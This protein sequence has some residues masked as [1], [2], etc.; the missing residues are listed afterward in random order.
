[1]ERTIDNSRGPGAAVAASIPSRNYTRENVRYRARSGT[2]SIKELFASKF[3]E[4][5]LDAVMVLERSRATPLRRYDQIPMVGTDLLRQAKFIGHYVAGKAVAFVGDADGMNSLLGMLGKLGAP[6]PERMLV[7]DFDE[8]VLEVARGLAE[9]YGFGDRLDLR[10][11]NAFDPVP[12]DLPSGYDWFYTNP[13]YGARNDGASARLFVARGI[14]LTGHHPG[15]GC[16]ILPYDGE[17]EWTRR[18]MLATQEFLNAAG[19]VVRE[20]VSELHRYHLDD[21]RGLAS[22]SLLVE[23]VSVQQDKSLYAGRRV[24]P[25]EIPDFYGASVPPPYPRYI[26]ADGSEDHGWDI[27]A[28]QE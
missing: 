13:P 12:D 17:R 23:R 10:R 19:W 15:A 11:Y 20:A 7:L 2:R 28:V 14:E 8:R 5:E 9:R 21:D 6:Q 27:P 3:T 26:H 16:L 22:S 25:E 18:A 1:M 4:M 24:T